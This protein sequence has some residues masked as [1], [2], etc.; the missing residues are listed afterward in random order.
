MSTWDGYPAITHAALVQIIAMQ[1][2]L[3]K[4]LSREC[5]ETRNTLEHLRGR[6]AELEARDFWQLYPT[7]GHDASWT[8]K[9]MHSGDDSR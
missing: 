8:H 9:P 1:R 4:D 2:S 3:L 5:D 7:Q 6:I